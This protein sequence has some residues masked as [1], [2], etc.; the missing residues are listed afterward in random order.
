MSVATHLGVSDPEEGVLALARV[1]WPVWQ[2]THP[3][4]QV[5]GD[6][7]DLPAWLRAAEREQADRVLLALAE[8]SSPEGAD[9]LAATG[10]LAWVLV[11][12][13]SLLAARLA[14]LT[15]R[16]DQLLAA[17]LWLEA[18][19]FPW[20]RGHRVAANILMNARKNVMRDL[21]VGAAADPTWARSIPVAPTAHLWRELAADDAAE[22]RHELAELLAWAAAEKVISDRD[23]VLLVDVAVTAD[24]HGTARAG[25]GHAGLLANTVSQEVATR[26]GVSA[27]TVRRRTRRSIL[28]LRQACAPRPVPAR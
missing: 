16:I 28:A 1:R 21:G 12:G 8:L 11:P 17:Q 7:L 24:R 14:T 22:A 15:P 10:T 13:I 25:R 26:A 2:R 18:R 23:R 3:V 4:L 27:I 19:T 20:Q 6:L 9:D 5:V